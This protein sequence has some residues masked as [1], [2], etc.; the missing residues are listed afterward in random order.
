MNRLHFTVRPLLRLGLP[1]L[2]L[3][4]AQRVGHMTLDT[5]RTP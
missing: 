4:R 2:L 1:A 5:Q 3:D